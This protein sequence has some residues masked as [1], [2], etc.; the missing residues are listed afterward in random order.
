VVAL[1]NL[2]RQVLY[3]VNDIGKLKA[4]VAAEKLGQLNPDIVINAITQRIT[5][6]NAWDMVANYDV[7]IDGS[8][9]FATRY[10]VN[11]VCAL[12]GK[13]LVMGSIYQY[14]GQVAVFNVGENAT[15]Y[16]DVFPVQPTAAEVPNCSQIGVIGVL[17]GI[18]GSMMANEAI[19]HIA[20]FGIPLYNTL[21][22]YSAL[23]N[24]VYEM[25]ILVNSNAR[26][27][28]PANQ[29]AFEQMQYSD[30]CTIT[31]TEID[32]SDFS[33]M[34]T[35]SSV[36]VIDVREIGELPTVTEFEH[37]QWPLSSLKNIQQTLTND[38]IVVFCQSGMRSL[39]AAQLLAEKYP[40]IKQINSL[41]GG[42]VLWKQQQINNK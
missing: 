7:V 6:A 17:P 39:Q 11:D 32:A 23:N 42:I 3:G 26:S 2:H 30:A 31:V 8:D 36:T 10:L 24:T 1:S 21:L 16:R 28:L 5:N 14:E 18:I 15:N 35:H 27:L 40:H 38:T 13:P 19:K 29:L 33:E 22:T 4:V 34:L 37:W 25:D 9:N 12:Q 41:K 20:G